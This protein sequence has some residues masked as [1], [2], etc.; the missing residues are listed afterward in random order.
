M[1]IWHKDLIQV[2]PTKQIKGEWSELC[3]IVKRIVTQ[4]TL[5][6]L[7]IN[8]VLKYPMQDLYLYAKAVFEEY[9]KRGYK[10]NFKCFTFWIER[11]ILEKIENNPKDKKDIFEGWH[12]KRY[13]KQCLYNLQEKY[14]CGG[15]SEEEWKKIEE[16]FGFML[17]N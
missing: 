14:D 7:L 1:R 8:K 12:N 17:D 2:L 3:R 10:C 15:I 4:G 11:G 16:K 9:T 5:N 6:H 13:L